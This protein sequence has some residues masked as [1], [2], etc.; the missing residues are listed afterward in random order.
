MCLPYQAVPPTVAGPSLEI[1]VHVVSTYDLQTV[2]A[3]VETIGVDLVPPVSPAS[4][5]SPA[6]SWTGA[7]AVG[8]LTR[9]TKTLTITATD[10]LTSTTSAA[11]DF[12]HD[13]P[14][15]IT[16]TS[17]SEGAVAQPELMLAATCT[18]DD[19]A[20]GCQQFQA[21]AERDESPLASGNPEIGQV[22]SL[23][24]RDGM[25]VAVHFVATDSAGSTTTVTRTVF[26]DKSAALQSPRVTTGEVLDAD[27]ERVLFRRD[28]GAVMLRVGANQAMMLGA[29]NQYGAGPASPSN[30]W[31]RL[32]SFGAVWKSRD[33]PSGSCDQQTWRAYEWRGSMA[34][35]F[36]TTCMDVVTVNGDYAHWY[37]VL[38]D[39]A[40]GQA[41][42]I[43][44]PSFANVLSFAL[45]PNGDL[46]GLE[47]NGF[48]PCPMLR[49]RNGTVTQFGTAESCNSTSLGISDGI[50]T[51]YDA[52]AVGPVFHTVAVDES[53]V[54]TVLSDD[55]DRA[56]LPGAV[57]SANGGW[58]AYRKQSASKVFQVW[59]R[60][61]QGVEKQVSPFG[62]ASTIETLNGAGEVMFT[63]SYRRYFGVG[64]SLPVEVSSNQGR[65]IS[66]CDGWYV[67]LGTTVFKV[68]G[69]T[70]AAVSCQPPI[71][72]VDAGTSSNPSN[73]DAGGLTGTGPQHGD[74]GLAG[75]TGGPMEVGQPGNGASSTLDAATQDAASSSGG[76]GFADAHAFA[77][78]A[79]GRS[80]NGDGG[81]Q[82]P[83]A[84]SCAVASSRHTANWR[85][86]LLIC[87]GLVARLRAR[88]R[89]WPRRCRG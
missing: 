67:A 80:E 40:S 26:V 53:G 34:Q 68:A 52:E 28:D 55:H 60:S 1:V 37:D 71:G 66:S 16:V 33:L 62:S 82:K 46:I 87:I 12:V 13:D 24:S 83:T 5:S 88:R 6:D 45:A 19:T 4:G 10:V 9:G 29:A 27:A 85:M 17:P 38:R 77:N 18:D 50:N 65:S 21:I 64:G 78:D 86:A 84:S 89:A 72:A 75:T 43:T 35:D 39:L 61:P 69:I 74:S 20:T 31:G 76:S 63:N 54:E 59:V 8:A 44:W 22:V 23:A 36:A 57:F 15:T 32:T 73:T 79:A 7:L 25:A 3:Q 42:T 11:V 30:P 81:V 41:A 51:V 56:E 2:H 49:Y 58:V 70:T 48:S 47:R 14:P